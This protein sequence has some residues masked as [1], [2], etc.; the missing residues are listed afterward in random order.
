MTGGRVEKRTEKELKGTSK[1]K[2][3]IRQEKQRR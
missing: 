1:S 3:K 2:D